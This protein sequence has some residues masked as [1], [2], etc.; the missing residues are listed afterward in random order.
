MTGSSCHYWA[1]KCANLNVQG[2]LDKPFLPDE[3]I[4]KIDRVLDCEETLVLKN[5][6]DNDY[7]LRIN[8]VNPKI[9]AALSYIEENYQN[10]LSR[11]ELAGYLSISPEYLSRL[12]S[13]ECGM[14]LK[15]Y[16]NY[17]RINKSQHYLKADPTLK[18]QDIAALTGIEDVNYFCRLFRKKTGMSPQEFRKNPIQHTPQTPSQKDSFRKMSH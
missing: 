9:K 1:K 12:F 15:E 8:I 17:I 18:I 3:L 5:R 14:T 10:D 13:Q 4:G 16:V 7:D 11:E 2:Y 6:Y